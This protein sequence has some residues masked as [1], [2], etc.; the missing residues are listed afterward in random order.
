MHAFVHPSAY[1]PIRLS[2]WA[3]TA[4]L[5]ALAASP[6]LAQD[7]RLTRLDSAAAAQVSLLADSA[8]VEGLPT[9]PLIQKALEGRA[10][11]AEPA[12][13][14]EAVRLLRGQLARARTALGPSADAAELVAGAASLR[15]GASPSALAELRALRR[16]GSL[17]VPLGVLADMV[18][19]GVPVDTAWRSVERLARAGSDDAAYVALRDRMEQPPPQRAPPAIPPGP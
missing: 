4:L 14:V 18:A 5:L 8:R 15:V 19:A 11:G 6:A 1:A 12:R 9:E 13:I 17:V 10:K 7:P 2:A 16:G 3:A